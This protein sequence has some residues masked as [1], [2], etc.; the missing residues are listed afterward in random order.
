MY[1][2]ASVFY[3]EAHHFSFL[4]GW[5]NPKWILEFSRSM[6]LGSLQVPEVIHIFWPHLYLLRF[7]CCTDVRTGRLYGL[8]GGGCGVYWLG[9]QVWVF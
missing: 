2:N 6:L 3:T 9:I 5:G 8:E 1:K 4:G 7:L